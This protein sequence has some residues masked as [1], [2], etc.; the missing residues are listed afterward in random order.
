MASTPSHAAI[1][2]M[3]CAW[4]GTLIAR[5]AAPPSHWV[6]ETPGY[7]EK[8]ARIAST[9]NLWRGGRFRHAALE[10]V[11]TSRI[12]LKSG[13]FAALRRSTGAKGPVRAESCHAITTRLMKL[14]GWPEPCNAAVKVRQFLQPP[15]VNEPQIC[16]QSGTG[17]R[18]M[19]AMARGQKCRFWIARFRPLQFRVPDR[20]FSR[21]CF[22]DESP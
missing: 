20:I 2:L 1:V 14:F 22:L 11:K 13:R 17:R 8:L 5:R 6:R 7:P 15:V 19:S 10:R 18:G 16:T 12:F 21:V 4:A 9:K 3:F